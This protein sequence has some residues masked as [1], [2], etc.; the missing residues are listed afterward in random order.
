MTVRELGDRM[1]SAELSEWLAFDRVSP[2]PDP[3]L[4][5]GI[6]AATMR[7]TFRGKR[8]RAA[9]PEDFIPRRKA[10][11]KRQSD[12]QMKAICRAWAASFETREG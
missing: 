1:D 4:I 10:G 8:D 2:L 11:P 6:Q 5:G 12:A 7:N 3:W 9:K